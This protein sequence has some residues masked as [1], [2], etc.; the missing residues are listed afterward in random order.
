LL[1]NL[2]IPESTRIITDAQEA[3]RALRWRLSVFS[4]S[5]PNEIN[6]AFAAL[7]QERA[8]ALIVSGDTFFASRRQ[9]IVALASRDAIPA[10]YSNRE[11]VNEGGLM[12][13]GND[14]ADLYRRAG[15]YVGRILK[16]DSP[17]DLPVERST[18]FEF[19][20]NLKTV[21]ALG[22]TVPPGILAIADE[23]ID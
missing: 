15:L 14:V 10:V 12:S 21:K 11:F 13:Y 4:A 6:D 8:D 22:L 16:G 2:K 5:T 19:L 3:T 18:K 1:T 7:R 20:I 9:Q 23:V 17:A